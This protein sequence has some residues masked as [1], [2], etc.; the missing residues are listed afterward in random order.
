[1]SYKLGELADRV[2]G[3]VI[4]DRECVID[5]VGSLEH[6]RPG[7]ITFYNNK[8]FRKHL[9]STRASAVLLAPSDAE[10]SPTNAV[11]VADPYLAYARIATLLTARP[12]HPGGIHP[13]ACVSA[14]SRIDSSAWVDALAVVEAG[15]RIGPRV[16]VGPGCSVGIGASIGEDSV[17]VANVTI[18]HG[19]VIGKRAMIHPGAVIGADGFGLANDGGTWVRVPQLGTVLVGDDVDVGANT[20][21]D[22]G[23][24]ED[25]VIEDGVKLD[26]LIQIGHNVRIGAHTAIAGCVGIAGSSF[27][28]K[29]CMLAGGVGVAGH[30]EIADNVYVTG[31]S[32]V[33]KSINE[34]GIYSAG[35]PLEP[36]QRWHK[37][38]ARFKQ[39]DEMARRLKELEKRLYNGHK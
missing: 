32:M 34:P 35:V 38:F 5:G 14:D 33:T 2:G 37:N 10:A 18:C 19:V 6:A 30:L 12:A 9:T 24:I 21:I 16:T 8:R 11:T 27:I 28:G 31:M 39:L 29:H 15:A 17:L 3:Q 1:M 23:T 26:N 13:R 36:N 4:G 22:R 25:T 7:Q 20:T